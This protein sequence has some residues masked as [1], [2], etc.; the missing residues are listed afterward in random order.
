[1][2][3]KDP[4]VTVVVL[5]WNLPAETMA[6]VSS[7]LAG[8]YQHQRILVV[9]NGSTD[10]SVLQLRHC[11]GDRVTIVET[12]TNLYYAGGNNV[13]IEWAL[14]AGADYILILNNDTV[15]APDMVSRLV[16]TAS[17]HPEAGILAPMIC[18]GHD[19]S[20]IWALG[21]RR[22][23]WLP[24]PRDVGR[25]EIDQGQYTVPLE[26][27]YVTGCAM[28]VRR[29]VFNQAGLFDP[30]YR[31]YYEDADLCARAQSAGFRLLVEPRAKMW[32]MVSVSAGRQAATTRYQRTRYRAR[33]YRQHPHGPFPWLTLAVLW[34]QELARMGM[35]LARG[36]LDLVA[37]GWRGLLDGCWER[38]EEPHGAD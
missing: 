36:Q 27:D 18:F 7:L 12:G 5:N 17:D 19:R 23:R 15:V 29:A 6:C 14:A 4:L 34:M 24:M 11:F 16:R 13:G 31:M 33:F 2:K 26:V 25:G 8:D 28:M 30:S 35:A 9:D 20:R 3:P 10:D 21:S 38:I 1:M 37:A 22:H 32:H